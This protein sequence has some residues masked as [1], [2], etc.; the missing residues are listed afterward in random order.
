MT[1]GKTIKNK[2]STDRWTERGTGDLQGSKFSS[3]SLKP[4]QQEVSPE[5]KLPEAPES[6]HLYLRSIRSSKATED[7]LLLPGVEDEGKFL[8]RNKNRSSLKASWVKWSKCR[9]IWI[10]NIFHIN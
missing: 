10:D 2:Q 9:D 4:H 8:C 1:E 5:K 6:R 7:K 3:G